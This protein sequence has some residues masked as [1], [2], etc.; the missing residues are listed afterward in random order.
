MVADLTDL[1]LDQNGEIQRAEG[2]LQF[3]RQNCKIEPEKAV[4]SDRAYHSGA[5][6]D[7]CV[8]SQVEE[9]GASG[10]RLF[11]VWRKRRRRRG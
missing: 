2:P 8:W 1:Y 6:T 3:F 9:R 10:M 4:C 11:F 7:R 5:E